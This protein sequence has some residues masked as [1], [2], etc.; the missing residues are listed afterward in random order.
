MG[1][2]AAAEFCEIDESLFYHACLY[3][4]G[5]HHTRGPRNARLFEQHDLQVWID[6]G[7]LKGLKKRVDIAYRRA[8]LVKKRDALN[9][10]IAELDAQL[11]ALVAAIRPR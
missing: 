4:L 2:K 6:S 7:N 5:P 11:A 8:D 9:E 1:Q 10:Q 3:G